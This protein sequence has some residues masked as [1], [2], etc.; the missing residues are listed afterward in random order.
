MTVSVLPTP[1]AVL[2]QPVLRSPGYWSGVV[3]RLSRD[4]V[5]MVRWPLSSRSC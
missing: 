5:A 3:R 2:L 4:P 1:A